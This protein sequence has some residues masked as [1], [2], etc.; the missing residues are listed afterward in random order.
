MTLDKIKIKVEKDSFIIKMKELVKLK[1]KTFSA[2]SICDKVPMYADWVVTP[3]LPRKKILKEFYLG[4]SG[5]S[6]MKSLI[7]NYT[8]WSW[9][10]NDI[11]KVVNIFSEVVPMLQNLSQ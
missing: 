8:Y 4:H 11:E 10:D 9:M 7:R 5:I 6:R 1:N 3:L 2:F